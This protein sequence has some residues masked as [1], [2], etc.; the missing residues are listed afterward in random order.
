MVQTN[1]SVEQRRHRRFRVRDGAFVL[2]GPDST[3]LGRVVDICEGGLAFNHMA[4]A[5]PSADLFELDLFLIDED[6]YVSEIPF[7]SVWDIKVHEN[8]FSSVTL[9]R[10]GIQ[11]G[12]L[13]ATQ[14]SDI[15]YF[16]ENHTL[17]EV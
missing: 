6:F 7:L 10:C 13:N 17:R 14:Q 16:I 11:F 12:Q 1:N 3:K 4:R 2:L 9:R 15:D 8:P 5:R